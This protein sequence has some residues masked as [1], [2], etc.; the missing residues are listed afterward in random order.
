MFSQTE[1]ASLIERRKREREKLRHSNEVT[2]KLSWSERRVALCRRSLSLMALRYVSS[3]AR[4]LAS[5]AFEREHSR[6][7]RRS[8][9]VSVFHAFAQ[10]SLQLRNPSAKNNGPPSL[11][12]C[13]SPNS[14]ACLRRGTPARMPAAVT[15]A[16]RSGLAGLWLLNSPRDDD[17]VP[18]KMPAI[19]SGC[20]WFVLMLAPSAHL[21]NEDCEKV[22]RSC[23]RLSILCCVA[24]VDLRTSNT[25]GLFFLFNDSLC[26]VF[27]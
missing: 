17:E 16:V 26:P 6:P 19:G 9:S 1:T 27:L 5:T 14:R 7:T 25:V 13:G 24:H 20:R 10:P 8:G 23:Y 2:Q 15:T 3:A 4:I 11:S 18:R 21:V 22:C 12:S